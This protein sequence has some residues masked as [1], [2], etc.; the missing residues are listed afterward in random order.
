MS[1]RVACLSMG[2][3]EG[4]IHPKIS[5]T[6]EQTSRIDHQPQHGKE[7]IA[8]TIGESC[9]T[10]AQGNQA[11]QDKSGIF[12]RLEAIGINDYEAHPTFLEV[13]VSVLS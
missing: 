12:T 6:G 2:A 10:Q 1:D 13:G 5:H 11:H 3:L 7:T 8:L 4:V 9:N